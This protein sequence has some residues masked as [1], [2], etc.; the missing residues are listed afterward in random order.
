MTD[1]M[2]TPRE[3]GVV[4]GVL[5]IIPCG[6]S[7]VWDDDP[8]RGPTPAREAYTGAPFKVN[9]T[10]AERHGDRWI[11]LSARYGFIPPDFV[12][13]GPYNVTFKR[14]VT[15]PVDVATLRDQ[16]R[17]QGL[18]ESERVVGLGGME[19]RAM[20]EAAFVPFGVAVEFPY[21]GLPIGLAMQAVKRATSLSPPAVERSQVPRSTTT[22]RLGGVMPKLQRRE[23]VL[24][25]IEAFDALGRERFLERYGFG[26]SRSY[27]L[28]HSGKLY[29]SKA[30]VGVAYGFEN[31]S[32]GP[33]NSADFVGG[34][35]TARR[36]LEALG[37]EVRV[38]K[39][40]TSGDSDQGASD[41]DGA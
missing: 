9:R 21:A 23:S 26:P 31:P 40:V 13:P 33:L 29:D 22:L 12:L 28:V 7:K 10:Y 11:I 38:L 24:K 37:F 39:S 25:A 34:W 15:N 32:H 20:I 36:W 27:F 19:Y 1:V 18:H 35:T 14:P 41:G 16:I 8:E 6:Q 3:D 30:M 17:D 4:D 5:V 2:T